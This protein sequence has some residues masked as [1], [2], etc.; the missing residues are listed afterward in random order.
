MPY[1]TDVPV[2]P[3]R[4]RVVK[5]ALG[6][7]GA[8]ALPRNVFAASSAL[9]TVVPPDTSIGIAD[10]QQR[11]ALRLSGL[12]N[13]FDFNINWA[14]ISGGPDVLTAWR[15]KAIDLGSCGGIPPLSAL[16]NGVD[17]RIVAFRY[18]TIPA[19]TLAI[20]PKGNIRDLGDLKGKK[21]AFSASQEQGLFVLQAIK[22]GGLQ[23]SDV[24]LVNLKSSEFQNAL[25]SNQIDAAPISEPQLTTYLTLF[26]RDGAIALKPDIPATPTTITA[27]VDSLDDPAKLAAIQ[28]YAHAWYASIVWAHEHRAEWIDGYYVKDQHVSADDGGRIVDALGAPAFAAASWD[29]A[30]DIIQQADEF[31]ADEGVVKTLDVETVLDRRFEP[32]AAQ[33]V[34]Q[35]YLTA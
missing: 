22:L 25:S 13:R 20:A 5:S 14:N 26:G 12:D 35:K 9:P 7:A 24:T 29:K 3:T 8:L 16:S 27:L 1:R 21:I 31:L 17:V 6:L 18:R 15:A 10:T 32:I 30:R 33:V 19:Y 4:R 11:V 23:R 34:P 2:A 28:A